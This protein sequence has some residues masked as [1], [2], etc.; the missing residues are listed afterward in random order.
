MTT[1]ALLVVALVALSPSCGVVGSV[2]NDLNTIRSGHGV[3]Q[4]RGD[5]GLARVATIRADDMAIRGYFS[6][7]APDGCSFACLEDRLGVPH[8]YTGEILAWNNYPF[9]HESEDEAIEAWRDSPPH[10][11]IILGCHYD[12]VGVAV[13]QGV[14]GRIY[15]V[16]EFA[17]A[18]AC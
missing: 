13:S 15:Y 7:D 18:L 3:A 8:A 10:L 6:H 17:G 1:A 14:D 11:A 4:V 16:A 12:S 9:G 5:Q 2:Y